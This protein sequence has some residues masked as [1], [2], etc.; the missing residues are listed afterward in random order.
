MLQ[1]DFDTI[2]KK[3]QA[4]E[5]SEKNKRILEILTQRK[6]LI[7]ELPAQFFDIK[8]LSEIQTHL[9][10]LLDFIQRVSQSPLNPARS[11]SIW[12]KCNQ[13][14]SPDSELRTL[15]IWLELDSRLEE[16]VLNDEQNLLPGSDEYCAELYQKHIGEKYYFPRIGYTTHFWRA[17]ISLAEYAPETLN[18]NG[19]AEQYAPLLTQ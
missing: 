15:D 6:S 13:S 8:T 7:L 10:I 11:L 3:I 14:K 12:A 2:I 19:L 4:A 9:E 1:K 5:N 18:P 16:K 17:V